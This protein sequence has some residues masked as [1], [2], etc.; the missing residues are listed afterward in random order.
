MTD[1]RFEG[2][3]ALVTGA[4]SG[5]GRASAHR[6]ASEGA[7][8]ALADIDIEGLE[9]V[10]RAIRDTHGVPVTGIWFDAAQAATC[11]RMVDQ[12]VAALGRLDVLLNIAG[13]FDWNHFTDFPDE[14]WDRIIG[15]DLSSLFHISKR[16]MPHLVESKGNIVNASSTAGIKGQAYCAAYCAAKHGV[17]GLTKSLAIEYADKGVRV[18]AVCPGGIQ[19]ALSDKVAFLP[20]Y[21][22]KLVM[23]LQSKLNGGAMAGPEEVAAIFAYLASDEARY[24]TGGTFA[25]D[26]GQLAG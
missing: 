5:I 14:A 8:L 12:A 16:A 24:I 1:R 18:N 9:Q 11:R 19:T 26:G 3:A 4:A 25:I 15:I 21:D 2:K 22:P 17:V 6:L 23:L 20:T 13:V 7:T 10:A